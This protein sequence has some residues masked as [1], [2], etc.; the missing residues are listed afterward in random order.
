MLSEQTNVNAESSSALGEAIASS[1]EALQDQTQG[2]QE[3][4]AQQPVIQEPQEEA[5]IPYSRFKEVNDE[6]NWFKSQLEQKLNQSSQQQPPQ[7]TTP[8]QELGNT[9]EERE[10]WALQ[11]KIAREEA[12]KIVGKVSPMIDAGRVEL[13]QI[14]VQQF[15]AAH[16]DVK[17]NS[18][19]ELMIAQRISSGYLPE[20]AYRVVMWDKNVSKNAQQININ[21]RQKI[22]A[23][24][25]ANVEQSSSSAVISHVKDNLT[26]RQRIERMATTLD[27]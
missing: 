22:E 8:Q 19:E 6:R 14:K 3:G 26:Q 24:K 15:R 18:N 7:P 23:K 2:T 5:K 16:P 20:D 12:E 21:N 10:F 9:P 17:A 1:P 4:T 13:A 11:R 25:Q 27:F